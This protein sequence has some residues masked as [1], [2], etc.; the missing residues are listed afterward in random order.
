MLIWIHRRGQV[1]GPFLFLDRDGVINRDRDD[2][3]KRRSEVLFYPD[4]LDAL[5]WLRAR[6]VQVILVSNQSGLARGLIDVGEFLDLRAHM[7]DEIRRHEG[8]LLAE[9]YCPHQPD[10]HC[11]CR[12]PEPGLILAAARIFHIP[13]ARATLI[14]DKMSDVE[15][16]RNAGC[17]GFLLQRP[18][19]PGRPAS[20]LP[21]LVRKLFE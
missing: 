5:A 12:K 13:L 6:S 21:T 16:A 2:Y 18:E 11:R 10:D 3:V 20:D 1:S 15:A 17:Q 14:G 7:L 19:A 8:D 9:F 4:A